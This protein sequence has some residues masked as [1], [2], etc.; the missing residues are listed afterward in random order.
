MLTKA[1]HKG[2]PTVEAEEAKKAEQMV[3]TLM[4]AYHASNGRSHAKACVDVSDFN[5]FITAKYQ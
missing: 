1:L 2:A 4:N 3:S 5:I